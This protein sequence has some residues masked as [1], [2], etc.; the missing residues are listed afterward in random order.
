MFPSIS[1]L[2][3]TT[4][5][6]LSLQSAASHARTPIRALFRHWQDFCQTIRPPWSPGIIRQII[7]IIRSVRVTPL[8]FLIYVDIDRWSIHLIVQKVFASLVQ[9]DRNIDYIFNVTP[10]CFF[11][12]LRKGRG[13]HIHNVYYLTYVS[14]RLVARSIDRSDRMLPHPVVQ[15]PTILHLI[16]FSL[17]R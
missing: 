2:P 16:T 1:S 4:L 3:S 11:N 17:Y 6:G 7:R 8:N 14:S 10:F 13:Y 12:R 15:F 5:V 9:S